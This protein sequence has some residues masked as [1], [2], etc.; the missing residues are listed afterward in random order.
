MLSDA[1]ARGRIGRVAVEIVAKLDE[2]NV[3][4]AEP[5]VRVWKRK[6]TV[7]EETYKLL[8]VPEEVAKTTCRSIKKVRSLL[9]KF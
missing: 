9:K 8:L 5:E 4:P 6:V 1:G 3:C 2:D 7:S